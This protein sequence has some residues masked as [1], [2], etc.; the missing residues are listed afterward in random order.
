[1]QNYIPLITGTWLVFS[2]LFVTAN[3]NMGN[4]IFFKVIPFFLGL[5]SMFF[6]VKLLGWL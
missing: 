1:M 6:G 4:A 5:A 2:A 3:S